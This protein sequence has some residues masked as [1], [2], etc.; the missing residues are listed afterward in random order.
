MGTKLWTCASDGKETVTGE[1]IREKALPR[2]IAMYLAA[3]GIDV[4]HVDLYF[5]ASFSDLS[6]PFRFPGMETAVKRL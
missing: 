4:Q 2:A 1:L 5:N 3:R 6:D